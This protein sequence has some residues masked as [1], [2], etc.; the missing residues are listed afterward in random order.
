MTVEGVEDGFAGEVRKGRRV[1]TPVTKHW[2]QSV[3]LFCLS[4][5]RDFHMDGG[6]GRVAVY[7]IANFG[8]GGEDD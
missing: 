6:A 5:G 3:K 2:C 4:W 1:A 8:G 7:G